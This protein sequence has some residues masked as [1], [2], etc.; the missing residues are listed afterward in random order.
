LA[1]AYLMAAEGIRATEN[2][3]GG[4][5]DVM[6]NT[7]HVDR[8]NPPSPSGTLAAFSVPNFR[9]FVAGQS[10]SLVGTWTETVA[11]ALLVLQL[12]NS[13]LI[14]GL[15]TAARYL[16]VLILTPYAGVIVDRRNKRYVLIA[17]Q[18]GLAFLSLV[19]GLL[20]ALGQAQIWSVFAVATGFGILTAI[21]N[22]ARQAF[23]PE[24]VGKGLI[25]NAVTLN[26]TF[27]NVGR[28]IGPIV[29][30]VLV[31]TV[32]IA[33]CFLLNA[34]SFGVVLVALLTMNVS[35]L[36]PASRIRSARGQLVAGLRYAKSV[37]DIIIPIAMMAVIGTFT[38][39][40]EVSLPLFAHLTLHG[41]AV[42]YSVL[43]G[44]FGTGSV[45]GGI[46]CTRRPAT[47]VLRL[48]KAASIYAVGMISLSAVSSL[49]LAVPILLIIGTASIT[50]ITT[51]NSTIQLASAPEFRGRVTALW[52]TAFIGSTPLGAVIIGAIGNS[53]PRA[54]LAVGGA[55]C[56]IAVLIGLRTHRPR[57]P[58]TLTQNA[59]SWAAHT[60][61]YHDNSI[62]PRDITR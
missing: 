62:T 40:F 9:R 47:G 13:G 27:V 61:E 42:T 35:Q 4:R 3:V 2:T 45:I 31:S 51:G 59:G 26:S 18:S 17:T 22:P 24:M 55:A 36:S 48:V 43:I 28:A 1:H 39:E 33:W 29:A 44:A 16:P 20:V 23:I 32:G 8:M 53:A 46:Y 10:V 21:D 57:F 25:R 19:L 34:G 60:K 37:P 12:T 38:Y 11:Q 50:F 58:L 56:F 7:Q 49:W 6:T 14:L 30:A 54:A 15:A 52:S 41:T 5:E